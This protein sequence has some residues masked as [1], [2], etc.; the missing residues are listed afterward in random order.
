MGV[1]GSGL[2]AVI[3]SAKSHHVLLETEGVFSL[4]SGKPINQLDSECNSVVTS[5]PASSTS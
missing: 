4:F 5:V 2:L 3:L 1:Y